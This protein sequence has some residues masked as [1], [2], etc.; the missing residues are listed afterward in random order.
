SRLSVLRPIDRPEDH[1]VARL[2]EKRLRAVRVERLQR[3]PANELPSARCFGRID[4]G[5][6][7]GDPDRAHRYP[8]P[9]RWMARRSDSRIDK[10]HVGKPWYKSKHEDAVRRG[11]VEPDDLV[12]SDTGKSG[13]A[14]KIRSEF[15]TVANR[16]AHRLGC[17]RALLIGLRGFA[18]QPPH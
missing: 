5:L 13:H 15:P 11:G 6:D 10:A 7:T 17:G 2:H 4:A 8:H 18:F 14:R 3:R 16:D 1:R 12:L 9:R